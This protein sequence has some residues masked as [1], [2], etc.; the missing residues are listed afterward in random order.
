MSVARPLLR[1]LLRAEASW[2]KAAQEASQRSAA[3]MASASPTSTSPSSLE[4]PLRFREPMDVSAWQR[5]KHGFALGGS[6]YH[7]KAARAALGGSGDGGAASL[8]R[9]PASG[10]FRGLRLRRLILDNFRA[11]REAA[12]LG[13]KG[14]GAG[15]APMDL[16]AAEDA[17]FAALRAL[18]E[19]R[20]MERCSSVAVSAHGIRVE[21][22]AQLVAAL[23][24]RSSSSASSSFVFGGGSGGQI[25]S[26]TSAGPGVIVITSVEGASSDDDD[27]DDEGDSDDG[28]EEDSAAGRARL[29]AASPLVSSS[30]SSSSSSAAPETRYVFTYRL[31]IT[32]TNPPLSPREGES[33]DDGGDSDE[34]EKEGEQE[35]EETGPTP[36]LR[37]QLL[38]RGWQ[39]RDSSGRL[40]AAVPKG[41][42]G[43]V[44]RTPVLEPGCTFEYYSS[45]DLPTPAGVMSGSF[46]MSVVGIGGGG[47][48]SSS[49]GEDESGDESGREKSTR[50]RRKRRAPLPPQLPSTVASRRF[51]ALVAP[52]ALRADPL[53][54]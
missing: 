23:P 8:P 15:A 49:D 26:V 12:A 45:T 47:D 29:A 53:K 2:R 39:I 16:S 17:G 27:D 31:R 13:E 36:G 30:S 34:E 9:P 22:T 52:F 32:N 18:G 14:E 25:R 33:D 44:G 54:R 1:A 24:S 43:V 35:Q 40:H 3:A 4:T 7:S 50:R 41:S 28:D 11:A 5:G 19:Q 38:S 46:G 51:E 48:S 20:A 21:A 6:V 10:V 42:P 37:L